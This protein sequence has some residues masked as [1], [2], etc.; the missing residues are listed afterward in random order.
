MKLNKNDSDLT[1]KNKI[2]KNDKNY[3]HYN[4]IIGIFIQGNPSVQN[5]VTNGVPQT[6]LRSQF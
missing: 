4:N 3:H 2:M 1:N 5:T 6:G